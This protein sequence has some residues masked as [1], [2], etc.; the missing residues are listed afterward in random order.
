MCRILGYDLCGQVF[1]G[2]ITWHDRSRKFVHQLFQESNAIR[3]IDVTG[4]E[5]VRCYVGF[6]EQVHVEHSNRLEQ[7]EPACDDVAA[8]RGPYF[9]EA[10]GKV[11]CAIKYRN[12]FRVHT[13]R[14]SVLSRW[15]AQFLGW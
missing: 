1:F 3:E 13:A 7:F 10:G 8:Y 15:R 11:H 5:V 2:L 4:V 9:S 14:G 6:L 12:T